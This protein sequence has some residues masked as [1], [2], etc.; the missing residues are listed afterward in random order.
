MDG[1][2]ELRQIISE[3]LLKIRARNSSY[4]LRAFATRVGLVP[5]AVSEILN[6]KR[7]I[8]KKMGR[9][10]LERLSVSPDRSL[11]ILNSLDF[12]KAKKIDRTDMKEFS[13]VNMDQYHV[14]SEWYYFAILSLAETEGFKSNPKWIANRLN[15]QV[16]EAST[17][18]ERLERL[19]ML[20][21]ANGRF[22]S[23]GLQFETSTDMANLS[24]RKSHFENLQLAQK[25]L[26][27]D[28]VLKRDF[29]SMTMAIDPK[30][31]PEA[32]KLIKNFRRRLCAYL[33]AGSKKEVYRICVQLFPLSKE[34]IE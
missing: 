29:S 10:I 17:A 30:R 5:S 23:T 2:T 1:Q 11:M 14:I 13:R 9:K 21:K 8:T 12:E 20:K 25:S 18:L 33:E 19:G 7:R 26:E 28:D 34:N 3:E 15:I 22:I 4:S 16:R 27:T 31:L 6:G 24:L 32:K